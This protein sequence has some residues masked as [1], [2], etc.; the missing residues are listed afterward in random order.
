[1][2][3]KAYKKLKK[4]EKRI[5]SSNSSTCWQMEIAP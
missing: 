5:M 4:E 1:M 2:N 3:R